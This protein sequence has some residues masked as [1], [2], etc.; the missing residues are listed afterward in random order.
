MFF[1]IFYN[2]M[3]KFKYSCLTVLKYNVKLFFINFFLFTRSRN[4]IEKQ[5]FFLD[6][7]GRGEAF[8]KHRF[9]G[10]GFRLTLAFSLLTPDTRHLKPEGKCPIFM[11]SPK[12]KESRIFF[13]DE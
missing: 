8:S 3:H 5:V 4:I 13:Q 7:I 10:S 2:T 1:I 9:Q 6:I 11:Q 12:I